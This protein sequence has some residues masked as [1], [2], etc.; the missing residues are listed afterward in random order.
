MK[1]YEFKIRLIGFSKVGF[2]T[3]FDNGHGRHSLRM[4]S[5]RGQ[6]ATVLLQFDSK[7]FTSEELITLVQEEAIVMNSFRCGLSSRGDIIISCRDFDIDSSCS[8]DD[9][10]ELVL[11]KAD[12]KST[13]M[14][15]KHCEFSQE[16]FIQTRSNSRTHA[17]WDTIA[18]FLR[19]KTSP[20]VTATCSRSTGRG[21][22]YLDEYT[23]IEEGL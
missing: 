9:V 4:A 2:L 13:T 17:H 11:V 6:H 18:L 7:E 8:R 19:D 21:N 3:P 1:K 15:S 20:A 16:P 23:L 14:T 22:S 10:M 5:S 12:G